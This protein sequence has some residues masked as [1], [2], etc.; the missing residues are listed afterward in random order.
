M[1]EA[2]VENAENTNAA[3]TAPGSATPCPRSGILEHL[4]GA[5]K[6]VAIVAADWSFARAPDLVD[7]MAQ[8]KA[9]REVKRDRHRR[10]LPWWLIC[11][12]TTV[13]TSFGHRRKRMVTLFWVFM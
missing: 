8:R 1:D 2:L 5:E 7:R 10:L 6:P 11:N 12:G 3:N 13:G 4:R 9:R